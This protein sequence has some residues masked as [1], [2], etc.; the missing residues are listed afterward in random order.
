[1][2]PY[3]ETIDFDANLAAEHGELHDALARA[4]REPAPIG[5]AAQRVARF[6][7]PHAEKEQR[8]VAPLVALLPD[9][10]AGRIDARMADAT[11]GFR[12]LEAQLPDLVAEHHVIRAALEPLLAAARES[13]RVDIGELAERMLAH[14]RS[15]EAV[16]YPAARLLGRYV[17]MRFGS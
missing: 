14:L 13:D 2:N 4:A 3:K 16:T 9:A 11:P 6:F 7:A 8:L 17:R 5:P 12:D 10:A 15:E 1:M